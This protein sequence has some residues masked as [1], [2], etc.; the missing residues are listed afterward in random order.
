MVVDDMK[1]A[2]TLPAGTLAGADRAAA[3]PAN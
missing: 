2:A 3:T 1:F